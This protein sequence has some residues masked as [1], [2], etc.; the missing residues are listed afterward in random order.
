VRRLVAALHLVTLILLGLQ[1]YVRTL[2]PTPEPIPPS[3][4]AEAAWWGFWP[5]TYLPAWAVLAGV[6][7]VAGAIAV[8]WFVGGKAAVS[9]TERGSARLLWPA[10]WLLSLALVVAFFAFPIAHTRWGDAFMLAKGIAWP[11]PALRLVDSWQAPLD[12]ALHSRIWA[13]FHDRFGWEDAMPVYRL[14][15]PIAGAL[16]LLVLLRLSRRP[17]LAP[18]WLP[19]ALFATLGLMQLFFGYV[20]NYS[21]AAAGVLAYL[22]LGLAVIEGRRPLWL[23]ATVLALTHATHPSTIVL[24]PSLLYLGAQVVQRT[25][26]ALA[27][28]PSPLAPPRNQTFLAI[29]LQIALPMVLIGGATFLW[30]EA[31]GHG[32]A[33]LL[34]T[35]RPGGG[36]ARWFVPLFA[37]TTRW[38]HYTLFSWPHLRDWLNGQLLVAPIVLPALA[39]VGMWIVGAMWKRVDGD[40]RLEI[41]DWVGVPSSISN[42]QSPISQSSNRFIPAARFLLI[43]AVCYLLF[44]FVWN[45]DY[46]GQRDWDLFSLAALPATLLLALLWPKTLRG[47]ALWGAAV[48][49]LLLQGWHTLAW[50]YQ[51]TLPWQW[52]D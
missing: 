3:A 31:N 23:A 20:E 2:P 48:P 12:V 40:W 35:D 30:M 46:G 11:D 37:A 39:V 34:S 22:W 45:P 51:N 4:S 33:A 25:N 14:L 24:A 42:L 32:V 9:G 36:D 7:A 21:F 28:R 5:V 18:G 13:N 27:P 49:L 6:L 50:I 17:L 29:V 41:G 44:T 26:R 38:E 1:L 10:L 52:P 19:Y 8:Y 47:R 16:Y 15:S 43:A